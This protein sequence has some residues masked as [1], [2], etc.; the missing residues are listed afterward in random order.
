M[1]DFSEIRNPQLSLRFYWFLNH[2]GFT[3][4]SKWPEKVSNFIV[5]FYIL[6]IEFTNFIKLFNFRENIGT[7]TTSFK[8]F[9]FFETKK[10]ALCS[11]VHHLYLSHIMGAVAQMI[12]PRPFLWAIL[13]PSRSK[14]R[15]FQINL[16]S[17]LMLWL[18]SYPPPIRI[19]EFRAILKIFSRV[20]TTSKNWGNSREL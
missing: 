6:S 11:F 2:E 5:I 10:L 8:V 15:Q 17:T 7:S 1:R 9:D 16:I 3:K 13:Y 12:P 20:T 19:P 14:Y 18:C 4:L